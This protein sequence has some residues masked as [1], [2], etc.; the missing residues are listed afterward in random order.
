[1]NETSSAGKTQ[2]GDKLPLSINMTWCKACNLCIAMCPKQ[3]FE[4]NR[5]G[6]P[7][8]PP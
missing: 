5:D 3:V 6:K 7:I 8:G 2:T 1:M 4:P